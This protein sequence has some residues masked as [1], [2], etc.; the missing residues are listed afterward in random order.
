MHFDVAAER[1]V[2]ECHKHQGQRLHNCLLQE[3]IIG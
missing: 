1:P 3:E 2:Y